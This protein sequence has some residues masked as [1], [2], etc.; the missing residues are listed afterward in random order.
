MCVWLQLAVSG[1]DDGAVVVGIGMR[2]CLTSL[3]LA[4]SSL[5]CGRYLI[6]SRPTSVITPASTINYVGQANTGMRHW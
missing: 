1:A 4:M 6:G 5:L 3:F 2:W